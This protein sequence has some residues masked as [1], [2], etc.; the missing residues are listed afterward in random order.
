MAVLRQ[1]AGAPNSWATTGACL[2]L[3]SS[4]LVQLPADTHSLC[5]FHG[6]APCLYKGKRFAPGE[7]WR[8]AN[9]SKCFCLDPL[10]VGCCDTMQLPL[11]F[12]EWCEVR[13]DAQACELS[14][15]QKAHPSL[16]CVNNLQHGWGSG[17]AP[18][19]PPSHPAPEMP[20]LG[21]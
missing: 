7:S 15:V 13:Y 1:K 17:R 4:L 10:G 11:D 14:L 18:E 12:P 9:C 20:P 6:Q 3:F 16:P 5:F 8:D 2:L 19:Q 21:R